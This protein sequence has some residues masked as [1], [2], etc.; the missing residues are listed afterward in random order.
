MSSLEANDCV[1]NQLHLPASKNSLDP[2]STMSRT[3]R[4]FSVHS[5]TIMSENSEPTISFI[6][7]LERKRSLQRFFALTGNHW[8]TTGPS[9]F[10]KFQFVI[11]KIAVFSCAGILATYMGVFIASYD[12]SNVDD[13][14]SKRD[15]KLSIAL[16]VMLFLITLSVLPA[17][18]FNRIRAHDPAKKEDFMVVDECLRVA[19]AFGL[20]SGLCC[21]AGAALETFVQAPALIFTCIA[22][23]YVVMSLM[24]NIFFLV[25]DLKVS[26]LL[27]DQLHILADQKLLTIDKFDFVRK[28]V[29]RRVS[30][31]KLTSDFVLIPSLAAAAG[32]II[33]V[34]LERYQQKEFGDKEY[35][36][37][38]SV[39]LVLIQLKELFYIAVAFWYVAK[40]NGRADELNVKLSEGFWGLYEN[41]NKSVEANNSFQEKVNLTDLHR[42]S[43]Y[44]SGISR[45]ISFTLLFKRLSW[46]DV[47]V[48]G[49]GFSV[50]LLL[51]LLKSFVKDAGL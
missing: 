25:L 28:E 24:F 12:Y 11:S 31:S 36:I 49:V 47:L 22:S 32:I 20:I 6:A 5:L 34:A 38:F 50:T 43:I 15:Y 33:S 7:F 30:A 41:P 14:E 29:H 37:A 4:H 8:P 16:Y 46:N 21:L 18:Y 26:L 45:P 48:S 27:L 2:E 10:A 9:I 23:L 39:G 19:Y 3:D 51:S 40:V 13:Y 17:Q 42:V 35:F 44:M 1:F